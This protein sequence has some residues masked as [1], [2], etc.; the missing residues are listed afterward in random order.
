MDSD[1]MTYSIRGV[2]FSFF[3]LNCVLLFTVLFICLVRVFK[4]IE[5]NV[6]LWYR[7]WWVLVGIGSMLA[8]ALKGIGGLFS[9]W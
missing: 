2:F 7:Y 4:N 5:N 8:F 9:V 1:Y 3:F 6:A